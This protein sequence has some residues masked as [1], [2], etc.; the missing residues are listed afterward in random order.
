M[1]INNFILKRIEY[2]KFK[3][4]RVYGKKFG[5]NNGLFTHAL[6]VAKK[7]IDFFEGTYLANSDAVLSKI[8]K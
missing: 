4:V 2:L 7:S 3:K 8:G 1:I 6:D 5:Q